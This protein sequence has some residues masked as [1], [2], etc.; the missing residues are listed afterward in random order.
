[1]PNKYTGVGNV[2]Q[3]S[4]ISTV[5][6]KKNSHFMQYIV[7]QVDIISSALI[8]FIQFAFPHF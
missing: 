5:L 8:P 3:S 4:A 2:K 1:M 6:G 7:G